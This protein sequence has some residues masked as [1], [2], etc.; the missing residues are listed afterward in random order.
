MNERAI[1]GKNPQLAL[2]RINRTVVQDPQHFRERSDGKIHISPRP[3]RPE[4]LGLL[5]HESLQRSSSASLEADLG[6]G[7]PRVPLSR[8][9]FANP[10]IER[11]S[12]GT[13]PQPDFFPDMQCLRT[14]D[15]ILLESDPRKDWKGLAPQS[16]QR[17]R[18]I[19][20]KLAF[21]GRMQKMSP[22][23]LGRA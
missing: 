19:V 15:R 12:N 6:S 21:G 8:A 16:C 17:E 14:I 23:S 22:T 1:P 18:A 5:A 13:L 20:E 4:W 3:D 2:K 10:E 7:S 9:V 11:L